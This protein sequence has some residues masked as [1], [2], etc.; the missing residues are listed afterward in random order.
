MFISFPPWKHIE[1][2]STSCEKCH[3][4]PKPGGSK[5]HTIAQPK[6]PSSV[7][8]YSALG[9]ETLR[10]TEIVWR[11]SRRALWWWQFG[12]EWHCYVTA[13][14]PVKM[15]IDWLTP[16]TVG[17]CFPENRMIF[18]WVDLGVPM[19]F[20]EGSQLHEFASSSLHT[21]RTSCEKDC[22]C[23]KSC[24][25]HVQGVD[26][27]PLWVLKKRRNWCRNCWMKVQELLVSHHCN[28]SK[29]D[30]GVSHFWQMDYVGI[31]GSSM[32]WGVHLFTSLNIP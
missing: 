18:F 3:P 13:L 28:S 2:P 26:G 10:S 16:K 17:P 11:S 9:W 25:A 6:P 7:C 5:C 20:Q 21:I 1:T 15:G 12:R 32:D 31:V 22:C 19:F 23:Q 4:Y 24:V 29:L 27:R 8:W 14:N 30:H